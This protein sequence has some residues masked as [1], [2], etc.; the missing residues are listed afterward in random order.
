MEPKHSFLIIAINYP[1]FVRILIQE[2]I[3]HAWLFFLNKLKDK[4][5]KNIQT[6]YLSS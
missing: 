5:Y 1:V 6:Q 3:L 2:S 4:P